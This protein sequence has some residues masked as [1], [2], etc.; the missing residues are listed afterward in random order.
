[1][2]ARREGPAIPVTLVLLDGSV[3]RIE[4][5]ED[6]ETF[7]YGGESQ[8]KTAGIRLVEPGVYSV[9]AGG[10]SYEARVSGGAIS[11][12]GRSFAVEIPDPRRWSRERNHAQAHGRQSIVASMPGKVVRVLVAEGDE[13]AAGQGIVV[14]EAMKMQNEMKAPRAGRVASLAAS[15]GATVKAGDVLASIE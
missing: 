11:I 6:G 5:T 3:V 9:I 15:P 12:G 4:W 8:E 7:R 13:V 2:A 10:R 14:V 1:M